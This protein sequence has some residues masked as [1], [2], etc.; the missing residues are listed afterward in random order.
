M[1][2]TAA[3]KKAKGIFS[4]FNEIP[5]LLKMKCSAKTVDEFLNPNSL[6]D[7]LQVRAAFHIMA[8]SKAV[9]EAGVEQK[10][11]MN[12]LIATDIDQMARAHMI[13]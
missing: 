6:L 3:G 10:V 9:K 4:Y 7:C 8:V 11:W 5:A 12:E 13:L 2:L 1:K